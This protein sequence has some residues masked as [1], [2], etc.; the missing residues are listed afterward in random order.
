MTEDELIREI[1]LKHQLSELDG[2]PVPKYDP[3]DGM[4]TVEELKKYVRFLYELNQ[5]KDK[6]I[7]RQEGDMSEIKNDLKEANRRADDEAASRQRLFDKLERIVNSM[8]EKLLEYI[9]KGEDYFPDKVWRA[10]N[11][12]YNFW[13]QIFAYRHDGEYS[14]DNMAVE[15]A[16]RPLTVQRKNSLFLCS[17]KGAK[18]SDICNTF[19]S[20]C[21]QQ[22]RN[23]RDFS[24]T[25]S[26]LGTRAE[27]TLETLSSWHSLHAHNK[28]S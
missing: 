28:I 20:T 10:L 2:T 25:M 27:G 17:E 23:F 26:G 21:V 18:N 13:D 12:F 4:E 6:C 11:Y 7:L 24:W 22:C 8:H 16:I 19:I 5:E 9:A 3:S 1:Q 14:I 15:R